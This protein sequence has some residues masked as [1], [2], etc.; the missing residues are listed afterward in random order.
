MASRLP[1]SSSATMS[2]R[3]SL[4]F[5]SPLARSASPVTRKSFRSK[6]DLDV[7]D[8]LAA[9]GKAKR[10]NTLCGVSISALLTGTILSRRSKPIFELFE[11]KSIDMSVASRFSKNIK[12]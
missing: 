10:I 4:C 5:L 9:K 8:G 11:F 3:V 12:C 6:E 1:R 7:L 2:T